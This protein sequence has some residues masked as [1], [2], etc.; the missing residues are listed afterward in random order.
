[1][2]KPGFSGSQRP[3]EIDHALDKASHGIQ[4]DHASCR[5][6]RLAHRPQKWICQASLRS[7]HQDRPCRHTL[8][9]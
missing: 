8:V 9:Q 7:D 1:V 6:I 2:A 3:E 4:V 5:D